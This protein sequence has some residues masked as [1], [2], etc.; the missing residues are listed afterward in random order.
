GA[1]D[2]IAEDLG[3]VPEYVRPHLADLGIAGFRIPHWDCNELGQPTPGNS[4]PENTFAT[5]S[6]HDHDPINGIWRAC[7]RV[8]EAHKAHPTEASGWAV[9]GARNT[10]RILSEFAGMPVLPHGPW[11]PY[12]E[13]VRLRLLKALLSSNSRYAALM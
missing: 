6:T 4:F 11:L 12:T 9:G 13:G 8:I 2:V 10:L 1:A 5:Y 7:L 3:W